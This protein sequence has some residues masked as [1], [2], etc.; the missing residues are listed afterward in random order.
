MWQVLIFIVTWV[1][2]V[3][4]QVYVVLHGINVKRE[5]TVR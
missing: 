5:D 1:A 2:R 4:R 3:T